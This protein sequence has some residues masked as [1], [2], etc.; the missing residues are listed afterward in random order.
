M[1]EKKCDM[2]RLEASFC[3]G[4][5]LSVM[6]GLTRHLILRVDCKSSMRSRV[7]PGMTELRSGLEIIEQSTVSFKRGSPRAAGS[8][9]PL[10]S[11][12][13]FKYRRQSLFLCG[14]YPLS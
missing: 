10:V 7:K 13:G 14:I 1:K 2:E 4:G 12:N 9:L 11:T 5:P 8:L 3:D 6:A